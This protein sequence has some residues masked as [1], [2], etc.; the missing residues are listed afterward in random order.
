MTCDRFF[1]ILEP[2]WKAMRKN[3]F[4]IKS[5]AVNDLT[6]DTESVTSIN[7]RRSLESRMPRKS[8]RDSVGEQDWVPGIESAQPSPKPVPAPKA[9]SP[10]VHSQPTSLHKPRPTVVIPQQPPTQPQK[11]PPP[12]AGRSEIRHPGKWTAGQTQEALLRIITDLQQVRMNSH[13]ETFTRLFEQHMARLEEIDY[14]EGQQTSGGKQKSSEDFAE[15]PVDSEDES[16]TTRNEDFDEARRSLIVKLK[17]PDTIQEDVMNIALKSAH[18][19][20]SQL[21]RQT[22]S[23]AEALRKSLSPNVKMLTS[24]THLPSQPSVYQ[25]MLLPPTIP[26]TLTACIT[27]YSIRYASNQPYVWLGAPVMPDSYVKF[28]DGVCLRANVPGGVKVESVK[29]VLS[30]AWNDNCRVIGCEEDWTWLILDIRD[31]AHRGVDKWRLKVC[32]VG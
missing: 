2:M 24:P 18:K 19:V 7:S 30:Y 3:L 6:T 11:R 9:I 12:D 21:A 1:D 10:H 22:I 29:L 8:R 23:D 28:R 4:E 13:E 16:I 15:Q 20:L 5:G 31:A 17:L 26:E 32:V 25:S 27:P 14:V